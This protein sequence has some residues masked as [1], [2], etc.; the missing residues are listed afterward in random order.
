MYGLLLMRGAEPLGGHWYG[1]FGGGRSCLELGDSG[2][3]AVDPGH[4]VHEQCFCHT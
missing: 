1:G 3:G 4:A 2:F